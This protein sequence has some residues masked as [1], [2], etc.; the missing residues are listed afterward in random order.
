MGLERAVRRKIRRDMR[1]IFPMTRI[2]SKWL[3]RANTTY[4]L[5]CTVS[6]KPFEKLKGIPVKF[7]QNSKGSMSRFPR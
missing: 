3:R 2:N 5:F 6:S 4:C 1:E 7:L